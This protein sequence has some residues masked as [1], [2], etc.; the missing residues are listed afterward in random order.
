MYLYIQLFR[1][2]HAVILQ[3]KHEIKNRTVGEQDKFDLTILQV[4]K[5]AVR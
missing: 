4:D 1:N 2:L 5:N 3:T